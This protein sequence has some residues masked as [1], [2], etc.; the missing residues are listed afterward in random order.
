MPETDVARQS[1]VHEI[2]ACPEEASQRTNGRLSR[3]VE[4]QILQS[5]RAHGSLS[6]SQMFTFGLDS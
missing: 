6:C 2:N 4:I 1:V 5:R 3:L